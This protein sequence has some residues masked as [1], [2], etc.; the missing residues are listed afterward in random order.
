MKLI[1]KTGYYKRIMMN[2]EWQVLET[3]PCSAKKNMEY[4]AHLLEKINPNDPPI[5]HIYSWEKPSLTYG[6]F[7]KP[8]EYLKKGHGI[9]LARRP[10]GGGIILH[11]I[12]F[13]FSV[14]VPSSHVGYS[15][16]PIE[17]YAFINQAVKK[18]VLDL[19]KENKGQK[20]ETYL[21]EESDQKSPWQGQF[22]MAAATKYD[23]MIGNRKVAGA[24]QRKKKQG[25]LHQG[26]ISLFLP[27]EDLLSQ[28]FLNEKALIKDMMDT[29]FPL[30]DECKGID[31]EQLVHKLKKQLLEAFQ[32]ASQKKMQS[33]QLG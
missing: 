7:I 10:T 15:E 12:D 26:S 25:F 13:A 11:M 33:L 28:I 22:C 6:Y 32:W 31:V 23:V 5:V 29:T 21:L 4:D 30:A 24:A 8:E 20:K 16:M 1:L 19:L 3:A 27:S 18:A 17:N 2:Q 9:D 14:V